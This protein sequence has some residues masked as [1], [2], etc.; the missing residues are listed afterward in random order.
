MRSD[1][2]G[3]H[4]SWIPLYLAHFPNPYA[5]AEVQGLHAQVI[6]ARNIPYYGRNIGINSVSYFGMR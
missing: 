1:G 5:A 2:W 6:M 4:Q 3:S